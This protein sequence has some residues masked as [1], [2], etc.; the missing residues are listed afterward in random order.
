MTCVIGCCLFECLNAEVVFA[1]VTT[2]CGVHSCGTSF[3]LE[4]SQR[5]GCSLLA[6][7][8]AWAE[9]GNAGTAAVPDSLQAACTRAMA[10][11]SQLRPPAR[12]CRPAPKIEVP[13]P[14]PQTYNTY[15]R[16]HTITYTHTHSR[17][18]SRL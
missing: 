10:L 11:L 15:T 7:T 2:L 17:A 4:L 14:L 18:L 12:A 3:R 5:S 9:G 13:T 8:V 1:D 6:V 16:T